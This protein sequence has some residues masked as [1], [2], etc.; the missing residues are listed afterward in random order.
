MFETQL[1]LTQLLG[2]PL[3]LVEDQE[4]IQTMMRVWEMEA[5]V[6]GLALA[7]MTQGEDYPTNPMTASQC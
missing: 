7:S 2:G 5:L 1:D 4:G 6:Y 3:A